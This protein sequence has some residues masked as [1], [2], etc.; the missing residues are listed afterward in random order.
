MSKTS[1]FYETWPTRWIDL[2]GAAER[3]KARECWIK[4]ALQFL[5][6]H[7]Q[8]RDFPYRFTSDDIL[9]LIVAEGNPA[10]L[11]R[12]W[13]GAVFQRALREQLIKPCTVKGVRVWARVGVRR[14]IPVWV[15][16]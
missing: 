1:R 5:R 4:F 11:A 15:P 9:N 6:V 8:N 2:S 10:P 13:M 3:A 7:C 12:D 14:G 16:A